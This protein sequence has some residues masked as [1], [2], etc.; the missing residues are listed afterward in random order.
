MVLTDRHVPVGLIHV[1]LKQLRR[2]ARRRSAGQ[3]TRRAPAR[4]AACRSGRLKTGTPPRLDGRTIDY[5]RAGRRSPATIPR[6]VFSFLGSREHASAPGAVLDH[7]HQRAHARDHPRRA[8]PLAAVHR[9]DRRHRPALLPVDRGQGRALRR[10]ATATR[11]S[12]SPKASR[13]TEIYPNGISTSLP[14]DVQLALVRSIPGSSSAHILRPGYAIE[15]DY[16]D[17]RALQAHAGDQGDRRPVLRRPD[18]RH[19]RLRGGRGAGPARR[20]QRRALRG[21][22]KTAGARAATRRTSACW[23]TT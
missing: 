2:R 4:A 19:D 23:S 12:S 11:S 16:F 14:F 17:P 22:A 5:S 1:G 20:H 8:R 9:R 18:Q 3:A 21:A 10:S 13:R 7:A 15:Y 6:P